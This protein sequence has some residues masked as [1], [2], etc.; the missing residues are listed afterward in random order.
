[1]Y[2]AITDQV[3]K[4][5]EEQDYFIFETIQPWC[6]EITGRQIIEKKTLEE[7]ITKQMN[8]M[9]RIDGRCM[10]CGWEKGQPAAVFCEHCGQRLRAEDPDE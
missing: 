4:A 3:H 9:P 2:S 7:V 1:M 6:Q 5:T 8:V 10:R